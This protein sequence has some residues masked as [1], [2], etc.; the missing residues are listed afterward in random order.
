MWKRITGWLAFTKTEQGVLLF[1]VGTFILGSGVRLFHDDEDPSWVHQAS[2]DSIFSERSAAG[3]EKSAR[4]SVNAASKAELVA[5]PGIGDV[6]AER[7]IMARE[8]QGPFGSEEDLLKVK[9][10]TKKK[11]EQLKPFIMIP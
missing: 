10:I 3:G 8:K 9:G 5:L 7:I 2:T 1:L 4:V 11:L 6:I